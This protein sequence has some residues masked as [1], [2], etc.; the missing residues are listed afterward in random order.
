MA[1]E[2]EI[3][4]EQ[5]KSSGKP[6]NVLEKIAEGKVKKFCEETCLLTQPYV[7]DPSKNRVKPPSRC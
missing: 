3:A 2:K 7:K 4:V 5:M 6:A 1:K